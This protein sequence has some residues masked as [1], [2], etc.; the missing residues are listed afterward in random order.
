MIPILL[1]LF[2]AAPASAANHTV[3]I[4]GSFPVRACPRIDAFICDMSEF[5]RAIEAASGAT[6][7]SRD[8]KDT[9]NA[10]VSVYVTASQIV[11]S[12]SPYSSSRAAIPNRSAAKAPNAFIQSA[13]NRAPIWAAIRNY[14]EAQ[15]GTIQSFSI[16]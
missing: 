2:L 13:G 12:I 10:A 4:N 5:Y 6:L 7:Y 15:G 8:L 3:T 16:E 14:V 11:I 9:V 1:A